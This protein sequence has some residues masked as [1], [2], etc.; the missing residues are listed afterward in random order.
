MEYRRVGNSG[1][2]VSAV[3]IGGW[4]TFGDR[5]GATATRQV[6]RCAIDNGVN[7]IDLADGYAGGGAERTVGACLAE[8]RRADLVISSKLFWPMSD[9][10]NDRGLSR[11]HIMES[12][13]RTLRHLRTDYLDIYFCHRNDPDTPLG[14]TIRAMDDLTH[15]GKILHWGTSLWRARR[16]AHAHW[17]ARRNRL[18]PPLVEQPPY[19]LLERW[20]ERR[21]VPATAWLGMGL[22]VWSPLA[23]GLLTG[24][25]NDGPQLGSRGATSDAFREKNNPENVR[26]IREMCSLASELHVEPAQLALAWILAQRNIASVI[27][28]ATSAAQIS[29]NVKAAD[30]KLDASTLARLNRLFPRQG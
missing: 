12:I 6:L 20:I 24:K 13:D 19:N 25:Y 3:S 23:G 8:F 17:I 22:V 11:K 14:E 26:R 2:R 30:I 1:L 10:I 27:T 4:L 16:L 5:L 18:T 7:F 21:L 28:G 15:Q 29:L 9:N